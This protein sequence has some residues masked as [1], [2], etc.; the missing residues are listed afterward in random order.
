[1]AESV[2][3]PL[4]TGLSMAFLT[5]LVDAMTK[6]ATPLLFAA[7]GEIVAER[8]G[9]L[10]LG[11]EGTMLMGALSAFVVTVTTGSLWLGFGVGMLVGGLAGLL[12]AFLCV[13]LKADQVIS[14][15]MITILG[16]A[17]TT[18]FGGDWTDRNIEGLGDVYF[19]VVG[20]ALVDVPIVGEAFFHTTPTDYVALLLVPVVWYVVFHTNLGLEIDAVGE[21]PESADTVG[22]P[23]FRLRYLTT[24]FGGVLGG[25]AGAHMSLAWIQQWSNGMTSGLGWIAIALVIVS[26]WR[27]FYA[28]AVAYVFATFNA[29][30]IRMQGIDVT[31]G[32]IVET[33][34]NPIFMGM[35][36][37]LATI[38]VLAWVSRGEV[39]ARLGGPS[40]LAVP[41]TREE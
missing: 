6:A 31:G 39:S 8:S 16:T 4:V 32:P 34:T 10:N 37:Y 9:V 40:A 26:R 23:V 2:V 36:P 41:Y 28:L 5:G 3:T 27:P 12:H 15:L 30:Q 14:G 33:L 19:P 13:T 1:M 20:R 18:F 35:Y 17:I 7:L 11:I 22:V 29:L 21:D 25:L 24:V 38:V